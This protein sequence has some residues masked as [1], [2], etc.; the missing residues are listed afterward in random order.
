LCFA[1]VLGEVI[2][3]G[4]RELRKQS[5]ITYEVIL[6]QVIKKAKQISHKETSSN[7]REDLAADAQT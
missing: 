2:L 1:A 3:L 4:E 7:S 5:W 6:Q